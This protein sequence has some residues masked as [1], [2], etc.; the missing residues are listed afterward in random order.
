V[1][2]R[3]RRVLIT[4]A[5]GFAGT[6]LAGGLSDIGPARLAFRRPSPHPIREAEACVV[7]DIGPDTDWK[8]CLGGIDAV[9]HAAARVHVG[10]DTAGALAAFRRTN[11]EGMRRLAEAAAEAGVR[12]FIHVSTVKV[13]GETTPE[14]PFSETDPPRP[15]GPYAISKWEAEQ[16]LASIAAETGMEVVIFRPPLMYGPRVR[17]NFRTLLRICARGIPVPLGKVANRR[18]FLYVG[19]LVDAVRQVLRSPVRPGCRTYLLRDGED[20]STA[21]MIRRI[22]RSMER[23]PRLLPVPEKALRTAAT[24]LGWREAMA[25]VLCSLTV[26]DDRFR[27]EYGWTAPHTVESGLAVTIEAFRNGID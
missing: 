3:V 7:G 16:V 23:N 10:G 14:A 22:A 8:D 19:N 18:S 21:D 24:L 4:G 2:K 13:N 15:E 1:A 9:V 6:A 25:K 27:A 12:R 5:S 20:L 26:N 17:G 11:V